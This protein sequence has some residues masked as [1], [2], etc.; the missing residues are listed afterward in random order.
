MEDKADQGRSTLLSL[1]LLELTEQLD[2]INKVSNT[3]LLCPVNH[4]LLNNR[5]DRKLNHWRL[6]LSK[7]SAI[8]MITL[9]VRLALN[10]NL[11]WT[12]RKMIAAL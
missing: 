12:C 5:M 4:L 7:F 2:I 8:S 6:R 11:K 10:M 1:R 3:F 9:I